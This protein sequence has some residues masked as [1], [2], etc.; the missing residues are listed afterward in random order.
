M[1]HSASVI[2]LDEATSALDVDSETH[3][4]ATL[5]AEFADK[6]IVIIAQVLSRPF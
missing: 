4:K 6:T 3:V 5:E 2:L 1:K